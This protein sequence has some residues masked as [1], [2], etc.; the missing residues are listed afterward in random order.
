MG[1]PPRGA[2]VYIGLSFA[3]ALT[4][5]AWQF[6][7]LLTQQG[8]QL[9][10]SLA[11]IAVVAAA[12]SLFRVFGSG[13]SDNYD[14]AWTLYGYALISQGIAPTILVIALANLATF[15][16]RRYQWPWYVHMFN[17]S[18][19]VLAAT[20]G[21]LTRVLVLAQFGA[22][23]P[24]GQLTVDLIAIVAAIGVFTLANHAHV[25]GVLWFSER[26]P[27]LKSGLFAPSSLLVDATLLGV[28]ALAAIVAVVNPFAVVLAIAPLYLIHSAMR[29][30]RLEKQALTDAK[31]G[32]FHSREFT[33]RAE[34]EFERAQRLNRPLALVMIDLDFLRDINNTHG[35]LAG[36]VAIRAVAD[37][38]KQRAR[39]DDVV[40]RFGGEEF[41]FLMV[42]EA[43]SAAFDRAEHLRADIE[44]ALP[45]LDNGTVLRIT[46]SLG[47]AER[48]TTDINLAALISRADAAM[49]LAKNTG[50]NRVHAHAMSDTP[51]P[52]AQRVYAIDDS[53]RACAL[54]LH[55]SA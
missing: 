18:S 9:R 14:V 48:D 5:S 23:A 52:A 53:E 43:R 30:P 36:D 21:G 7:E 17:I 26:T 31:T 54:P 6:I 41:A 27:F 15:V 39:Q 1:S 50:R 45:M 47:L 33:T 12:L 42:E 38:L 25:A 40:A 3:L 19:F 37:V 34:Q 8:L 24:A 16:A 20:L 44:A 49:Y 32:L 55:S 4:I 11:A 29:I 35:H 13:A 2:R 10:W 46:A 28:G 22:I 51:T